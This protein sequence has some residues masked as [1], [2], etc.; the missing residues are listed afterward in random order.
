MKMRTDPAASVRK[1]LSFS[2]I[3]S[4]SGLA[5]PFQSSHSS[6]SFLSF[7]PA[8]ESGSFSVMRLPPK[9]AP[10]H[11]HS[12][13]TSLLPLGRLF[14]LNSAPSPASAPPS[15]SRRTCSGAPCV[16]RRAGLP[17]PFF[18]ESLDKALVDKCEAEHRRIG[19]LPPGRLPSRQTGQ[20][21]QELLQGEVG[22]SQY[23]A[24]PDDAG[25]RCEHDALPPHP[26]HPRN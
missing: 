25:L 3:S 11:N 23:V 19:Q 17:A 9:N 10:A 21:L 8:L 12:P 7:R 18:R 22:V 13:Y 16:R 14:Q 4:S 24:L 5:D 26:R 1:V 20:E 15:S 2:S 6:P